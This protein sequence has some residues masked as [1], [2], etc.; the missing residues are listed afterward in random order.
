MR[1]RNYDKFINILKRYQD[2]VV[3]EGRCQ[4]VDGGFTEKGVDTLLTMDLMGTTL[5]D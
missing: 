2:I 3:R 5:K 1:R 4:K